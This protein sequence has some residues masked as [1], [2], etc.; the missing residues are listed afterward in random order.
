[1]TPFYSIAVKRIAGILLLN[2]WFAV[3]WGQTVDSSAPM[4]YDTVHLRN[5]GMVEGMIVHYRPGKS[6]TIQDGEAR[7]HYIRDEQI[8]RIIFQIKA[9]PGYAGRTDRLK[10]VRRSA[11]PAPY[12]FQEK[13]V[14][15]ATYLSFAAGRYNGS[16]RIGPG[17]HNVT[18]YQ[19]N[20][21]IGVGLGV[22]VDAY[23]FDEVDV[24]FPV[25]GEARGYF[26]E[27]NNS[28][29]Y[30]FSAGYG[31]LMKWENSDNLRTKGGWMIHPALGWRIGSGGG[32]NFIFDVGYKFQKAVHEIE[33]PW[34]EEKLRTDRLFRRFVIRTGLIF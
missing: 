15:N 21:W 32:G 23:S 34:G 26:L 9:N 11:G 8:D 29:Y 25:Y 4:Q 30:S 27:K 13:G 16:V 17:L 2:L 7:Y 1:M 19:F 28:P 24:V 5:G 14:Y 18:G 10:A 31:F 12:L 3:A 20:R 22:G 33:F 6:I